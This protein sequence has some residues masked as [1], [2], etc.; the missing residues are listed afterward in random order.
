MPINY[1]LTICILVFI[2]IIVCY[3]L[4]YNKLR[5]LSVKIE[6]SSSGID[7]AL[8]KRYD[9]LS[10]EIEAV[11]KF[12]KHEYDTYL[13]VT[14]VRSG[15][16]FEK[17]VLKEKKTLSKEALNTIDE[18]IKTQ[19]KQMTHIRNQIETQH[20]TK[21]Y[22]GNNHAKQEVYKNSMAEYKMNI[23]QKIGLLSSIQQGLGVISSTINAL[24]EQYPTLYS[25][26]SMNHFQKSIFDA[27]EH[28]QAARRLYNSN[29]SLYNQTIV[30]FPYSIVASIHGMHKADFYE[31]DEKKKEYKINFN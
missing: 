8:E 27:E 30:M 5:R 26:I 16:E 17:E 29:V 9:M 14:S 13:A 23:N 1:L 11:K 3:I 7:V 12:L 10:E 4:I 31:V 22:R 19:Q 24:S 18:I 20:R 28:L 15:K 2:L 21:N 25:H 6:E